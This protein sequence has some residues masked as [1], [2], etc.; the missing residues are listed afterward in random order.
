[1]VAGLAWALE[2]APITS[3]IASEVPVEHG[4]W[5]EAESLNS[6]KPFGSEIE[7][8]AGITDEDV[9]TKNAPVA[10]ARF[11]EKLSGMFERSPG[12]PIAT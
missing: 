6:L 1:M 8:I 4:H 9:T 11:P 5:T 10:V 12:V 3:G 2:S 7:W